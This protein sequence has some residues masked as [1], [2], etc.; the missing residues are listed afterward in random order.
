MTTLNKQNTATI[1]VPGASSDRRRAV[2][3]NSDYLVTEV[4]DNTVHPYDSVSQNQAN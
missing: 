2:T 4:S 1:Y 3:E